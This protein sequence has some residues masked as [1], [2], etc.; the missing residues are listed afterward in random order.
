MVNTVSQQVTNR[1]SLEELINQYDLYPALRAL[2]PMEDVVKAM[3]KDIT[4][5]LREGDV[6]MVSFMGSSPKQAMQVTNALAARFIEENLRF[7]G[8]L[9]SETSVYVKDELQMAKEAL[10]K[11]EAVMRDYK[12]TYYNE[13]PQQLQVNMTHLA[14]LQTQYQ[15]NQNSIQDMERTR[16]MIQEQIALRREVM[17]QQTARLRAEVAN[18]TGQ[19]NA[20]SISNP[21]GIRDVARLRQ[22]LAALRSRYTADHPEVKRQEK[23]LQSL[24]ENQGQGK[25][26]ESM[27]SDPQSDQLQLQLRDIQFSIER[28]KTDRQE[29]LAQIN[30]TKQWIEAAPVREAEWSAL[31]RDYDQLS[32]HYQGLV[33][34]RIQAESTES[35]ERRQQGTQFKIIDQA[36]LPTKP[37][38]P[39]FPKIMLMAMAIGMGCGLGLAFALENL[40]T[41]FKDP[42]DLEATL[43]IA[44]TCSIPVLLTQQEQRKKQLIAACWSTVF[45]LTM[46]SL[47]GGMAYLWKTGAIII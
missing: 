17:D 22:E 5:E 29:I 24:L 14:S 36:R 9:A 34:Q 30:K 26:E 3:Q 15:N 25:D 8:E 40:D 19:P 16:V 44:V 43:G 23:L 31:T 13:M 37:F 10:D 6:F 28:L 21:G 47:L 4:T 32:A 11:K 35:L 42:A 20:L 38:R 27:G 33:G 7:R 12:L 18:L 1:R 46:V 41:S 45:L 2:A 39:D